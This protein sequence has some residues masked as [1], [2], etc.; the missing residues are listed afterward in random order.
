MSHLDGIFTLRPLVVLCR[1][2]FD[3]PAPVGGRK[4]APSRGHNQVRAPGVMVARAT[5]TR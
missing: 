5:I 4:T 1:D 2:V 3:Y